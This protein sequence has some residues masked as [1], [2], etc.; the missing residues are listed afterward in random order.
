MEILERIQRLHILLYSAWVGVNVIHFHGTWIGCYNKRVAGQNAEYIMAEYSG[1]NM[2][3]GSISLNRFHGIVLFETGSAYNIILYSASVEV[4]MPY[5][6][7]LIKRT[8]W[9]HGSLPN[10]MINT[11]FGFSFKIMKSV[12]FSSMAAHLAHSKML[13]EETK[14][15]W[16]Q[17]SIW[18]IDHIYISTLLLASFPNVFSP[19]LKCMDGVSMMTNLQRDFH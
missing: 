1:I 5:N 17:W 3:L 13:V 16:N 4:F 15:I 7:L 12:T 9:Q 11:P 18:P 14:T 8:L 2:P 10:R 6:F 19:G